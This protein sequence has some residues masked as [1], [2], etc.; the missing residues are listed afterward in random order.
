MRRKN[1][2]RGLDEARVLDIGDRD[3]VHAP[4]QAHERDRA[5]QRGAQLLRIAE[6]VRA[7]LGCCCAEML[8]FLDWSGR[9]EGGRAGAYEMDGSAGCVEDVAERGACLHEH[10]FDGLWRRSRARVG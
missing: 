5:A 3:A 9:G 10:C 4:H 8:V 7:H 6:C 1:T 2:R